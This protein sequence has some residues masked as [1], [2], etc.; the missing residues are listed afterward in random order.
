[1]ILDG[2]RGRPKDLH[3][4]IAHLIAK[5][6]ERDPLD[7]TENTCRW[8]D[9]QGLPKSIP[10]PTP[11]ELDKATCV[12]GNLVVVRK[13]IRK[14]LRRNGNM[15]SVRNSPLVKCLFELVD[16]KKHL[17]QESGMETV[18][19]PGIIDYLEQSVKHVTRRMSKTG[20]ALLQEVKALTTPCSG[21]KD[22]ALASSVG[23]SRLDSLH[24]ATLYCVLRLSIGQVADLF[25][26]SKSVVYRGLAAFGRAVIKLN[27][28]PARAGFSG[29][30]G[31]DEKWIKVTKSFSNE[32]RDEGKKWRY[33]Y[34]QSI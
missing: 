18:L 23:V 31:I 7:S 9:S 34:L 19:S 22:E 15:I 28:F 11:E 26:R 14:L 24:Y 16:E 32:E 33:A 6:W 25:G 30:L 2:Q 12:W 21:E 10:I 29:I 5:H 13:T 20:N 3:P 8:L 17:L 4:E 1:M 27:V